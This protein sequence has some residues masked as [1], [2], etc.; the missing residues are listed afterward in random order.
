MSHCEENLLRSHFKISLTLALALKCWSC[1]SFNDFCRDPFSG[2]SSDREHG[3]YMEE[4]VRSPVSSLRESTKPVCFKIKVVEQT[5]DHKVLIN[6]NCH[7][8]YEYKPESSEA[9]VSTDGAFVTVETCSTDLCN[10]GSSL[11][12]GTLFVSFSV[13]VNVFLLLL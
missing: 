8:A 7:W 13:F 5:E 9:A 1:T 2:N 11:I 4:C 12:I 10:E 6:R 3:I